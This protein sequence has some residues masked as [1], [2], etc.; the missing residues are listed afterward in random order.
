[1]Y[2][3]TLGVRRLNWAPPK[4]A[5]VIHL[6]HDD[7][8]ARILERDEHTCQCCGFRAEKHQE[9]LHINGDVR[10]FEDANVLTTCI[11]CHQCFDL[12][13]VGRMQS[14]MLIWL[15]EVSQVD[16]HHMMRAVYLARV[17]QGD[18]A[19][20][21][22]K[23]FDALYTRSEEV[24]KRLGSIDP[25]VLALVL[26]DFLT[27]KHY[28]KAQENMDG[29]RLLPLDRRMIRD[30]DYEVNYFPQVLAHWRSKTGPYH[31]TPAQD[32][33]RLYH[34]AVQTPSAV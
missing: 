31:A 4:T 16:L 9:I 33:P 29:I 20:T 12:E 1:M 2:P 27:N 23:T 28:R 13:N 3:I 11:F 6:N 21:A 8:R 10:D 32:W 5:P 34:T 26:K 25:G 22:R 19:A 17:T 30:A 18:L 24:K 14:G 15:P 7:L